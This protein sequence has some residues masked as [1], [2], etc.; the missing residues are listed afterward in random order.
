MI[1]E[2]ALGDG[3]IVW[4]ADER[5]AVFA[6]RPDVFDGSSFP[7][8][9]LPTI[10]VTRGRE[11]RRPGGNRNLQPDSPWLVRLRMEPE[12]DREPD[13]YTS[14]AE[15]IEAAVEL[16]E[17]FAAGGIDYRSLYQV[18]RESYLEKL[19]ELTGGP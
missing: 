16:T 6:Y 8:P 18:P 4:N 15:A 12:I 3:W 9:C 19:D 11:S 2:S 7:S 1:E 17:Q 14:R 13:A 5:R 10:Y